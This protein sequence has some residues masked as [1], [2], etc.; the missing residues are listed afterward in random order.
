[1]KHRCTPAFRPHRAAYIKYTS[2]FLYPSLATAKR[3][4]PNL[5]LKDE[6]FP[7]I[8]DALTEEMN[9]FVTDIAHEG[10]VRQH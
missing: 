6:G 8:P 1:V 10:A 7:S 3:P 9:G 5:Q 2:A 4:T